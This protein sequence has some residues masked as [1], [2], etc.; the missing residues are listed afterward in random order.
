MKTIPVLLSLLFMITL[1]V[2]GQSILELKPSQSM[3]IIGKGPGQDA[4]IN[5]Y[6]N[7]DSKAVIE[8][9]GKNT[10]TIRIQDK[11]DYKKL[12]SVGPSETK[13]LDL[14]KGYEIYFDSELYA[15]ANLEFMPVNMSDRAI[16]PE[17]LK[18][19]LGNWTGSLTYINYGSGEPYT[20]PA[21]L[22]V[23]QGKSENQLVLSNIYPNEPK[24]NGKG[25]ISISKDGK[26]LN[27]ED[28][29]SKQILPDGNIKITTEYL[30]KDN[31]K[32]ALIRNIYIMG[33][34]QLIIRKEVKFMDSGN[35]MIRNEY[36]FTR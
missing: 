1:N 16:T 35:W 13:E 7:T 18:T 10:F 33:E 25:K 12:I 22:I 21:D 5:P 9:I 14:L 34:E 29:K 19:I 2:S 17:D 24:A 28:L 4:A 20:M 31:R 36:K 30:G 3:S 26:K 32:K 23:E 11:K 8:N 15:K 27:K 6:A